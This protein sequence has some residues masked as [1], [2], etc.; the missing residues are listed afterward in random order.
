MMISKKLVKFELKDSRPFFIE[1]TDDARDFSKNLEVDLRRNWDIFEFLVC[2]FQIKSLLRLPEGFYRCRIFQTGH[3][4]VA[5][6][7]GLLLAH[8]NEIAI[9][10]ALVLHALAL[11]AESEDFP[12]EVHRLER[13]PAFDIFD[14]Q[15]R[16]PGGDAP[17]D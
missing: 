9:H 3:D 1:R 6:V 7:G 13:K 12:R 8:D 5:V 10:D 4:H 2:R 17:D 15:N 14:G 16:L 11:H